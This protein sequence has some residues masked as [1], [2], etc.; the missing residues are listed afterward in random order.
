MLLNS[1]GPGAPEAELVGMAV[2]VNRPVAEKA[3]VRV[4]LIVVTDIM[5]G[6]Q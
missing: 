1:K 3:V 2:S 4:P 6:V 5:K